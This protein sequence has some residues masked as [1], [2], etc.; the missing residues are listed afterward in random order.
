M[1]DLFVSHIFRYISRANAL[2]E[3]PSDIFR[4]LSKTFLA[5]LVNYNLQ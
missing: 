3:L 4:G 5:L 1:F 2:K